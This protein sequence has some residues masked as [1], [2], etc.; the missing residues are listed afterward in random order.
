MSWTT[1]ST[2]GLEEVA[3]ERVSCSNVWLEGHPRPPPPITLAYGVTQFHTFSVAVVT[4]RERERERERV[5]GHQFHA[6]VL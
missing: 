2:Q 4:K 5:N 1:T 6:N 3:G